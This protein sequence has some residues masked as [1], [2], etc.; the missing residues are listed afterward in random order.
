MKSLLLLALSFPLSTAA[1]S[2]S[3]IDDTAQVTPGEETGSEEDTAINTSGMEL[4][5]GLV[6]TEIAAFQGPKVTLEKDG[7]KNGA[8]KAPVIAARPGVVRVYVKPAADWA[9]RE[10]VATLNLESGAGKKV[11]SDKKTLSAPSIDDDLGTTFN[12]DIGVDVIAP[13]TTY[14]VDLKTEPGQTAGGDT[15]AAQYPGDGSKESLDA[16]G[17]GEKLQIK[18]VPVKYNADGSGRLPDTSEGQLELYRKSFQRMYPSRQVEITVRDPYNWSSAIQRNGTGFDQLLNGILR[19]RQTDGAPK[20]TYY[21]GA[22]AAASTF[23]GWCQGGCVAGLS[24]LAQNPADT[25]TAASVGVGWPGEFSTG[26]AVHEVG[27][28]HGRNHS[29]CSPGGLAIQGVDKAYPYAGAQ[30]GVWAYDVESKIMVSPTK[31]KDF[32]GYC[33]PTFVS[34]YTFGALATR[35]GYVYGAKFMIPGPAQTYRMINVDGAGHMES[36]GELTMNDFVEGEPRPILFGL[37]GG[38]KVP[39]KAAFYPYDH[40]PGGILMVPVGAARVREIEARDLVPG[41]VSKLSL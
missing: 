40:L 20:G 17:T 35:M 34:D 9:P 41:V 15:A 13:D 18:I 24:P 38:K 33:D 2:A 27:H 36:T 11:L 6:I 23:M 16:Q 10:V 3:K 7:V 14:S 21:F 25:W 1:C 8:R 39:A 19:L 26:S 32:M 37:D 28:G 29:P 5:R 22:F 4:V 12:F 31:N 30:L